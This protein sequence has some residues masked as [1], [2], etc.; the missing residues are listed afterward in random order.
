MR[1]L[2]GVW[3]VALRMF[4]GHRE[5]APPAAGARRP[6]SPAS[7]SAGSAQGQLPESP[8]PLAGIGMRGESQRDAQQPSTDQR[9]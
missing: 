7:P 6:A 4:Q 1:V 8:K 3:E 2:K 9:E 5:V